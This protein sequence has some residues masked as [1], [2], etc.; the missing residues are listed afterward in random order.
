MTVNKLIDSMATPPPSQN[1]DRRIEFFLAASHQLKSPVA[2][3]QWCL[4]SILED[5]ALLPN[6][7]AELV[8]KALLQANAMS[9]LITDMLHVFK[10]EGAERTL[11]RV[12][13]GPLV[14]AV[15]QQYESLAHQHQVSLVYGPAEA[16]P[17]VLAEEQYLKQA[18]INLV[19]NAIKYSRPGGRVTVTAGV[20]EQWVEV[21]VT[22]QGIGMTPADQEQLFHEFYRSPEARKV[23][24]EGTGLGLV[25]VKHIIEGFGGSIEV[26]SDSGRGS[27][28]ILRLPVVR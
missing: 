22:D 17:E 20:R 19:D 28:F 6:A 4:Q 21:T 13:L 12:P 24:H 18:I 27:T 23:A 8:R 11:V 10:L 3:I 2:I 14:P 25:L 1:Q 5:Q 15:V 26:K 9:Q 16:L 7:D